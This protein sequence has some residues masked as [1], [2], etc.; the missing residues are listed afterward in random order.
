MKTC[1]VVAA[2]LVLAGNAVGATLMRPDG[3]PWGSTWQ[4]WVDQSLLPTPAGAVTFIPDRCP[5]YTL[6]PESVGC[7]YLE[8]RVIYA[9]RDYPERRLTLLHELGHIVEAEH[10]TDED[11]AAWAAAS[12]LTWGPIARERFANAYADCARHHNPDPW[13]AATCSWIRTVAS[14]PGRGS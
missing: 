7:A 4:R 1:A 12:G 13:G 8:Q 9:R 3:T 10:A 2:A 5:A 11:R 6:N 14:R